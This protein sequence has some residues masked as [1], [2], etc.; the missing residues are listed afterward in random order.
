MNL[1]AIQKQKLM[2]LP[3][4]HFEDESALVWYSGKEEKQIKLSQVLRIVP[5]QRT[6]Y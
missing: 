2:L 1:D 5:G 6:F 3:Q 4:T